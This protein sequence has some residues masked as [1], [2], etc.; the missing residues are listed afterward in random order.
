MWHSLILFWKLTIVEIR[1]DQ[2]PLNLIGH[3]CAL[4]KSSI[5]DE[6]VILLLVGLFEEYEMELCSH[7]IKI[8]LFP[9]I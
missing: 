3:V 6:L 9:T 5:I 8:F 1:K 4:K 7:L 2:I